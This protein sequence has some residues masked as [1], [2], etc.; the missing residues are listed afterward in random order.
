MGARMTDREKQRADAAEAALDYLA[1]SSMLQV[2]G[3]ADTRSS[4]R[5]HVSDSPTEA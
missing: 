1:A 3:W 5:L 2:Q 4:A